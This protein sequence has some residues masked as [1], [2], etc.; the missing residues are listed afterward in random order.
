MRRPHRAALPAP[1]A[2]AETRMAQFLRRKFA[3]FAIKIWEPK[4]APIAA[5][6]RGRRR[7]RA[8]LGLLG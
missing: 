7:A 1:I 3:D 6:N 8:A 4:M 2:L 5:S